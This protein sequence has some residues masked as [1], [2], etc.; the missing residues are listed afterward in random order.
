[1][2]WPSGD[3]M[4]EAWGVAGSISAADKGLGTDLCKVLQTP[5]AVQALEAERLASLVSLSRHLDFTAT[6]KDALKPLEPNIP[7]NKD[8]LR[9]R[10]DCYASNKDPLLARA[11]AD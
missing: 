5:F 4:F 6:C 11:S 10:Y 8:L 2:R 1:E 9:M 3:E 7:W